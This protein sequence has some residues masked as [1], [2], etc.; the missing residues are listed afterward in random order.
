MYATKNMILS[1]NIQ[2]VIFTTAHQFRHT[3][4]TRKLPKNTWMFIGKKRLRENFRHTILPVVKLII[5]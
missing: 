5:P 1:T 3:S 4:L 2:T